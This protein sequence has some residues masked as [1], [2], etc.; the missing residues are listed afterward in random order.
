MSIMWIVIT[1]AMY[2]NDISFDWRPDN[3][4]GSF[5][6]VFTHSLMRLNYNQLKCLII[7]RLSLPPDKKAS[8][9]EWHG[10]A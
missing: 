7:Y 3:S 6:M 8:Y 4:V 10:V 9:A 2:T 1:V 5:P